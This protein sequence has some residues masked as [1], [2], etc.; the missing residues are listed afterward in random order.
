MNTEN[1]WS[2]EDELA[3]SDCLE[4]DTF[5]S[6]SQISSETGVLQEIVVEILDHLIENKFAIEKKGTLYRHID[7]DSL[8]FEEMFE[9][10]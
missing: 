8:E 10:E 3:I 9:D 6:V 1:K 4:W 5:K 7:L 2:G